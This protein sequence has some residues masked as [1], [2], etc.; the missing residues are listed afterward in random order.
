MWHGCKTGSIKRIEI[1]QQLYSEKHMQKSGKNQ[2]LAVNYSQFLLSWVE[3][4]QIE[5]NFCCVV[6][7]CSYSIERFLEVQSRLIVHAI[8]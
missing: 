1:K 7:I 8:L 5:R 3:L 2:K 4:N 6:L